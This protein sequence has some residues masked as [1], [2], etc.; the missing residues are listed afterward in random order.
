[1]PIFYKGS[2]NQ[3]Q[4]NQPYLKQ[5]GVWTP[6]KKVFS[7]VAGK[8]EEI[9][10]SYVVYTHTGYGNDL[11]M[12]ACF[13]NPTQP[14]NFIFINEGVI[15]GTVASI[16][17]ALVTGTFPEGSS[18]QFINRG[19][20]L[21]TGGDGGS[22]INLSG[23]VRH[24]KGGGM[25]LRLDVPTLIDNTA[26]IIGG[27]GGGGGGSGDFDGN[28]RH[29]VGGAGGAG[30]PGGR[31]KLDTW[32]NAFGGAGTELLGGIGFD[33]SKVYGK[34]GD[35]GE[36]GKPE[37]R[38][39]D[40]DKSK[41]QPGA[42]GGISIAN[43]GYV[44]PGSVGLDTDRVFGRTL[45]GTP[46]HG[47]LYFSSFT[48]D[49]SWGNKLYVNL[50]VDGT[51]PVTSWTWVS[52]GAGIT[53]TKNSNTQFS[54]HAPGGNSVMDGMV[55]RNGVVKF[56]LTTSLGT[57]SFTMRVDLCEAYTYYDDT[58]TGYTCF[59]AGSMVTMADGT[60]KPI[61]LVNIGEYVKTA[62][63]ITRVKALQ[64][65]LLANR[66]LY[67]LEDGTFGATAD[68]SVWTRDPYTFE[69]WWGVRDMAIWNYEAESG[70]GPNFGGHKPFDLTDMEGQ[71][72]DF[73]HESGW[74]RSRWHRVE[75]EPRTRLYH[76]L[77]EEGGSYFVDGIL[78]SS[79]A[80]QSGVD[81]EN[82]KWYP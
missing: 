20:V 16:S 73:A 32:W 41:I 44:L 67:Y 43:Y 9:W 49:G 27:G 1:M 56:T 39:W 12:A 60:K 59:V 7:K 82:F 57:D 22:F 3:L 46:E 23:G 54:F 17:P 19:R 8:W 45:P 24:P 62:V 36:D 63:G 34:G 79:M 5:A 77:L 4:V 13:G 31:I 51:D 18:L 65:P 74:K 69:Q 58:N 14:G 71:Y 75:A 80:D 53:V 10:P 29:F 15:G 78:V 33:N 42:P 48:G 30:Y 35:L 50:V 72:W 61:E 26:G 66:P 64:R 21:G 47:Q 11:N 37:L 2:G 68:H 76:L 6:A 25:A 81:W 52:G 28:L 55:K 38:L 70:D 40:D